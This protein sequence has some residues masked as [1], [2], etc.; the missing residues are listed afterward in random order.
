MHITNKDRVVVIISYYYFIILYLCMLSKCYCH[1]PQL[2]TTSIDEN[3][4]VLRENMTS[5]SA[6]YFK[7]WDNMDNCCSVGF[8]TQRSQTAHVDCFFIRCDKKES[9]SAR[10]LEVFVRKFDYMSL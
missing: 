1:L 5:I 2:F 10:L 6:C 3:D 8:L 7:C 4:I 9:E